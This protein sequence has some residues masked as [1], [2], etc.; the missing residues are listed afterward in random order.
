MIIMPSTPRLMTPERSTTS[1]PIA[2]MSKGVAAVAIVMTIAS[3]IWHLCC[4]QTRG[5][6]LRSN[7]SDL[8]VNEGVASQN[9]EEDHTLEGSNDLVGEADR[10]LRSFATKIGQSQHE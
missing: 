1:S 6:R 9:E 10:N 3:N 7:K 4:S 5:G 8:V 2:A